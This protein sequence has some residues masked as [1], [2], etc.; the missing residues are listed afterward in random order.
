[1]LCLPRLSKDEIWLGVRVLLLV[2]MVIFAITVGKILQDTQPVKNDAPT[3]TVNEPEP[4]AAVTATAEDVIHYIEEYYPQ[5]PQEITWIISWEIGYASEMYKIPPGL[6]VAIIEQESSFNVM[7]KGAS[8]EIGLMQIHPRYWKDRL[9]I[10][11]KNKLFGIKTNIYSGTQIIKWLLEETHGDLR[12]AVKKYNGGNLYPKQVYEKIGRFQMHRKMMEF[13]NEK[14]NKVQTDENSGG[15][16]VLDITTMDDSTIDTRGGLHTYVVI[17]GDTY[18]SIAKKFYGDVNQWQK[19][20]NANPQYS[21]LNLP[22]GAEVI[23]P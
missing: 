8:G 12:Q 5:V 2:G 22:V 6:I 15:S 11:N 3:I 10:Q 1:M 19:I 4:L 9:G 20:A 18:G 14:G 21:E 23:I 17:K 16:S 7:A 13:T